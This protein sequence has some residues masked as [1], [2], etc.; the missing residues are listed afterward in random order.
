MITNCILA[1]I[2]TTEILLIVV[3]ILI[4]FGASAIPKFARSLGTAKSEFEKGLK[5]GAEKKETEKK[6]EREKSS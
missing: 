3:V 1:M 6:D 2:G 4:I 5:E